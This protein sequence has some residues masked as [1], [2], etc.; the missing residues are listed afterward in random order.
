MAVQY[1][2][3]KLVCVHSSTL[4]ID[5]HTF[6]LPTL[7]IPDIDCV[8]LHQLEEEMH[9]IGIQSLMTFI[10]LYIFLDRFSVTK[11]IISTYILY[12]TRSSSSP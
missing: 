8:I 3:L 7:C 10:C 12:V 1:V 5:M 11:E 9:S 6:P 2:A 4:H